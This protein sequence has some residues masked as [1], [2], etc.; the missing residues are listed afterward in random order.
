MNG[1]N[2]IYAINQNAQEYYE[3]EF[4][5][6]PD[7]LTYKGASDPDSIQILLDTY[8]MVNKS[9]PKDD[10]GIHELLGMC[11]AIAIAMV[12]GMILGSTIVNSGQDKDIQKQIWGDVA[13]VRVFE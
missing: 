2:E 6:K 8:N 13:N 11:L 12:I 1:S 10:R 5:I 7:E 9:K 4:S 3:I